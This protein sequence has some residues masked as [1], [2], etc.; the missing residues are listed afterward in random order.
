MAENDRWVVEY[1]DGGWAVVREDRERVSDVLQ[2]QE[3]A[4]ARG[5]VIV[6]NLGGG[7][8]VIKGKDGQI[9]EKLTIAGT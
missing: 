3:E 6:G 2:T 1:P 7:E 5:H 8:L 4:I 9:R